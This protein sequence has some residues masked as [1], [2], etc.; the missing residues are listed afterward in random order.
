MR[1]E[2]QQSYCWI[3]ES[4]VHKMNRKLLHL[5]IA[6]GAILLDHRVGTFI[7]RRRKHSAPCA[8]NIVNQR[9]CVFTVLLVLSLTK[10]LSVTVT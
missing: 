7:E 2:A 10:I 4:G 3:R 5:D 9:F 6:R 8:Q 1:S